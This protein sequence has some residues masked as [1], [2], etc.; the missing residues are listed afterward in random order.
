MASFLSELQQIGYLQ[1]CS[2]ILLGIFSKMTSQGYHPTIEELVLEITDDYKIGVGAHLLHK[3]M[4]D[5]E[6][7]V[8]HRMTLSF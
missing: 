5:L 2:G 4:T 1:Q 6:E 8:S 7:K 3:Q